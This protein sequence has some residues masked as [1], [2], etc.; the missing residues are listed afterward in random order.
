MSWVNRAFLTHGLGEQGPELML[1]LRVNKFN[2]PPP[3]PLRLLLCRIL[4]R[5]GKTCFKRV[6]YE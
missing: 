2:T 5:K 4:A 3:P 1:A 6:F